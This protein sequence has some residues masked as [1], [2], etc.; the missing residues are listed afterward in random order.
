M[1]RSPNERLGYRDECWV[2]NDPDQL[3]MTSPHGPRGG[4]CWGWGGGERMG[5][6][7]EG[8]KEGGCDERAKQKLDEETVEMKT[9]RSCREAKTSSSSSSHFLLSTWPILYDTVIF[10]PWCYD[11]WHIVSRSGNKNCD[12]CQTEK[13]ENTPRKMKS[14]IYG[15]IQYS[16]APY[17]QKPGIKSQNIQP[18]AALGL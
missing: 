18:S 17:W 4:S 8:R 16:C 2:I 11:N 9:R 12:I 15:F 13:S 14:R 7:R 1:A 5:V 10:Y 3:D 6:R